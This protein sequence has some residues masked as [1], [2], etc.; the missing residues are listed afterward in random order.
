VAEWQRDDHSRVIVATADG[1]PLGHC[2]TSMYAFGSA[3]GAVLWVRE[4]AVDPGSQR[5][6]IGRSLLD[7]ALAWGR[8]Q[9]AQRSF[10]ACDVA[11][12]PAIQL[13]ESLG[14]ARNPGRG[15]INMISRHRLR[16]P[17]LKGP[18]NPCQPYT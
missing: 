8:S 15:Q 7:Y 6:G 13:Y 10:L 12:H 9:G 4:L 1:Q 5:L 17:N 16:S 14:Y 2:L 18:A 3:K 11:N